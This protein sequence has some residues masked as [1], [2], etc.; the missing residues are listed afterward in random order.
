MDLS[1][2]GESISKFRETENDV[3]EFTITKVD[4]NIRRKLSLSHR[5]GTG[6]V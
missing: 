2:T 4:E 6:S 5:G 1:S 3:R